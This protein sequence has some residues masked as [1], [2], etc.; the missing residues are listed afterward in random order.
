M[1]KSFA[2]YYINV[3]SH[4][5][6]ILVGSYF[7]FEQKKIFFLQKFSILNKHFLFNQSHLDEDDEPRCVQLTNQH[8]TA[9]RFIRKVINSRT[10]CF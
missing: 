1:W 4:L 2:C 6:R 10:V 5:N 8:K 9:I 3:V 7:S